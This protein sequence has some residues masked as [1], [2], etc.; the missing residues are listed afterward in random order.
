MGRA[1]K[2]THIKLV[3]NAKDR[4]SPGAK[5]GEPVPANPLGPPPKGMTA[6]EQ[7]VWHKVGRE[8]PAGMLKSVDEYMMTAFCRAVAIADEATELLRAPVRYA[9]ELAEGETRPAEAPPLLCETPNGFLQQHAYLSI[10]NKQAVII[11]TLGVELGL[12]PSARTR[13][14]VGGDDEDEDPTARYFA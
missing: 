12:S 8:L 11:K 1:R 13:I 9:A 7:E 6:R 4:R 3:E 10:I 5:A 2:P 14:Q